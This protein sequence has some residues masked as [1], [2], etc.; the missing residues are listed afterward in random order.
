MDPSA[1]ELAIYNYCATFV[2]D[3]QP[4][5]AGLHILYQFSLNKVLDML[6][7][8]RVAGAFGLGS[9]IS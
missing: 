1:W 2:L 6:S 7:S 5:K 3:A 9:T 4:S 8:D